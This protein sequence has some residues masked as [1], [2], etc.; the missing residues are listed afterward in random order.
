MMATAKHVS[1]GCGMVRMVLVIVCVGVVSHTLH[2]SLQCCAILL[3]ERNNHHKT[4]LHTAFVYIKSS[5][6]AHLYNVHVQHGRLPELHMCTGK[7]A[8]VCH[9]VACMRESAHTLCVLLSDTHV[10]QAPS[11]CCA[12]ASTPAAAQLEV[13]S[14]NST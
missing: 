9:S 3:T 13:G 5:C 14:S 1:V 10:L 6:N 4:L 7:F 12:D 2:P 11:S 8:A